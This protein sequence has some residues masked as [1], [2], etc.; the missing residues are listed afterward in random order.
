MSPLL[1]FA[2][3]TLQEV[4]LVFMVGVY[5]TRLI[6]LHKFKAGADKSAP[7]GTD[8]TSPRKG[9][10]YSWG[11]IFMPWA[12]ESTRRDIFLWVQFGIFHVGVTASLG[13]SFLI[14]YAP[15]L[16]K[17]PAV[18][19]IA[20]VLFAAAF[21]VG[22]MRIVRR[23][24]DP[25]VRAISSPDDH[26]SLVM[27][28]SWFAMAF[29]A[30]TNNPAKG[31]GWLLAYFFTTALFIIYVPFSKISHYLYYPFTRMWIG[32]ALGRRGVYPIAR[33]K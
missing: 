1:K 8:Y 10:F 13:M 17:I 20:Q 27:L 6:W 30:A 16:M 21:I 18:V 9:M 19:V 26:F 23:I 2:E 15:G 24:G 31:E 28:T 3:G 32:K 29:M 14:P 22:C 7:A 12:M 5:I 33:G 25:Y 4:A 11:T